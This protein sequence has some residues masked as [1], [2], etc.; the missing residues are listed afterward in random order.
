MRNVR[1]RAGREFRFC[2]SIG[3]FEQGYAIGISR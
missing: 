1:S 3:E 2:L